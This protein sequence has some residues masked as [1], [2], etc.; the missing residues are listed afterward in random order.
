[1]D[2]DENG[3]FDAQQ[4]KWTF[5][6]PNVPQT[7]ESLDTATSRITIGGIS[8]PVVDLDVMLNISHPYDEDLDVYLV[9]PAGT[10]VELFSDVGGDADGFMG[11]VLDGQAAD[12]ISQGTAPFTGRYRPEG[13]LLELNGQAANG[14]WALEID[15]DDTHGADMEKGLA[16]LNAWSLTITVEAAEPSATTD[17]WGVYTLAD[18]PPGNCVVAE[19]GSPDWQ[20]TFPTAGTH[21]VTVVA[22]QSVADVDFG[23]RNIS[24]D[25]L[26]VQ[27]IA[28]APNP[29][30]APVN[31][32]TIIF[33]REVVGFDLS[34]LSLRRD[35]AINLLNDE[36]TLVTLD[37]RSWSLVNLNV[38]TARPG[39]Y[40]LQLLA[41]DSGIHDLRGHPLTTGASCAFGKAA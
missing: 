39:S 29:R 23:N 9:S 15:D 20:T 28:V 38:L 16:R 34:D 21:R 4:S 41:D 6:S 36:A 32:I 3:S 24:G 8:G 12:R 26:A 40:Q 5:A 13:D 18:I 14:I 33:S 22:N 7:I 25:S 30:Y 31:A 27:I 10:R 2:L 1:M 19:V 37:R 17:A 35:N 11:T